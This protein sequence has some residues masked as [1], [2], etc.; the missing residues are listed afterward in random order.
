MARFSLTA[1]V[2]G[3]DA[4]ILPPLPNTLFTRDSSSWIYNGVSINPMYWPARRK[5][6]FNA[7]MVYHHHPMFRDADFRFWFPLP[8]EE[9][10]SGAWILSVHRL[11]VAM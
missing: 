11:K 9:K 4:F 3:P 5:E 6:A 7:A 2:S 1:A 10:R 8:E